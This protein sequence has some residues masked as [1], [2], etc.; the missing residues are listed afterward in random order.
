MLARRAA[1]K[2][3]AAGQ[4]RRA[5]VRRLVQHERRIALPVVEQE[6]A[7]PRSLDPLEE[8]LRNDLIRID[9][10]AAQRRHEPAMREER[11]S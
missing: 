5:G 4:D 11:L 2:I 8:L 6:R 7:E 3:H 9:V 10:V 1:A